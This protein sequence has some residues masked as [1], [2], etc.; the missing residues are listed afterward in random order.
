MNHINQ[1]IESNTMTIQ[2]LDALRN[3]VKTN[4][5][6]AQ[7]S[8]AKYAKDH[9]LN[10]FWAGIHNR[11]ITGQETVMDALFQ[12][13]KAG[14]VFRRGSDLDGLVLPEARSME[15][16]S[17]ERSA[18]MKV[19]RDKRKAE[20]EAYALSHKCTVAEAREALRA[21]KKNA[22]RNA[23]RKVARKA[24]AV[25]AP[26]KDNVTDLSQL[27]AIVKDLQEKVG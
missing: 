8:G 7:K 13:I 24:Q 21:K 25:E 2:E 20:A 6:M 15:Q 3:E 1:K 16:Y 5:N 18:E 26:I 10:G 19:G 14:Y 22:K 23:R 11:Q 17:N 27:L 4:L 9:G 12:A